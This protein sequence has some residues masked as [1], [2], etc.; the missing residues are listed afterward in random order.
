LTI[1]KTQAEHL[2][3]KS[4]VIDYGTTLI[5]AS[6]KVHVELPN[7][8]IAEY[9]RVINAEYI[10]DGQTQELK[11]TLELCRE[12]LLLAD[13]MYALKSKVNKINKLKTKR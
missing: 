3:V 12:A 10:V 9:F 2:V 1:L 13:Y 4:S 8:N 6:D 7:G 11:I 5:L